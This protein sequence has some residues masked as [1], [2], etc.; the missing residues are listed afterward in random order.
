MSILPNSDF[1]VNSDGVTTLEELLQA[2]A[3]GS[4]G[5]VNA[6]LEL[7][8]LEVKLD[9]NGDGYIDPREVTEAFRQSI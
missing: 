3:S 2:R 1:D 9:V 5:F 7:R 4:A 6:I 8:G